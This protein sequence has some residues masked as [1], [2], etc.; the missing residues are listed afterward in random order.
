MGDVA[1]V[2]EHQK[3]FCWGA[4]GRGLQL[5]PFLF[6]GF[7]CPFQ[8]EF[9][10]DMPGNERQAREGHGARRRASWGE[11]TKLFLEEAL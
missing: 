5:V 9:T 8:R 7:D 11:L 4:V 3:W 10:A 1:R 6:Q 2:G